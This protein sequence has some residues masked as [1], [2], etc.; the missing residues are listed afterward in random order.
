[1]LSIDDDKHIMIAALEN[2]TVMSSSGHLLVL[3]PAHTK[4]LATWDE[5][6]R[7]CSQ[8]TVDGVSG[9]HL[10]S[11]EELSDIFEHFRKNTVGADH[12][13]TRTYHGD[14]ILNAAWTRTELVVGTGLL[15]AKC[16]F[17]LKTGSY[18]YDQVY[19]LHSVQA[20]R[21]V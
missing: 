4:K 21:K 14:D 6:T 12:H 11:K 3:A 17:D 9:W 15:C 7:Y 2:R 13:C 10:P 19:A 20:I 18:F 16:C 1:M 8:L 5:A